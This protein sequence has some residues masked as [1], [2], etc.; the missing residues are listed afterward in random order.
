MPLPTRLCDLC[1]CD[2][3]DFLGVGWDLFFGIVLLKRTLI[4]SDW[5]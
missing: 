1:D 3:F 4:F 2:D 5:G